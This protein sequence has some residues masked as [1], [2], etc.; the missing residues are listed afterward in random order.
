MLSKI[1]IVFNG[2]IA[3][4]DVAETIEEAM[5]EKAEEVIDF[6]KDAK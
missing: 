5:V 2:K 4:I 6:I 1:P 3:E